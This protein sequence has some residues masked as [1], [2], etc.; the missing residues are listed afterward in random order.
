MGTGE[1]CFV[2]KPGDPGRSGES[3]GVFQR[4][5]RWAKKGI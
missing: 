1:V 4:F 2:G 5:N 3:N